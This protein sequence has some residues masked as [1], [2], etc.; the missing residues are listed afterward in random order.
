V[1]I[2]D[3]TQ[4]YAELMREIFNFDAIKRLLTGADGQPKLNVLVNALHGGERQQTM[5]AHICQIQNALS[6]L[7]AFRQH[8][9]CLLGCNVAEAFCQY[10]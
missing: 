5:C 7:S 10:F 9:M 8:L 2:I 4:D 3:T 6:Y 1:Q